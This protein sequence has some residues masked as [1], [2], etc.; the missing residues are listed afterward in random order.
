MVSVSASTDGDP[1]VHPAG[2]PIP[3][4]AVAT[5]VASV[6]AALVSALKVIDDSPE[7]GPLVTGWDDKHLRELC[8]PSS[9]RY[10]PSLVM[11]DLFK[12]IFPAD[13][14]WSSKD[15]LYSTVKDFASI[16]GFRPSTNHNYIQCSRFGLPSTVR[17]YSA[18]P[19]AQECTLKNYLRAMHNIRSIQREIP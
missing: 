10:D 7:Y 4:L 13:E 1:A 15:M 17:N 19:L 11:N 9:P 5:G 18:G 8:L 3:A 6:I 16:A 2:G 12:S 14:W